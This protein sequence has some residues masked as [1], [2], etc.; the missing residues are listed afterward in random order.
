M[1]KA[2]YILISVCGPTAAGKTTLAIELAKYFQTEIISADSRQ[3]YRE[4]EIGTAKPSTEELAAVPHHFINSHSITE[5]FSVADFEKAALTKLEELF[6]QHK[7]VLMVGGSGLYL[8]AIYQGFDD[9]PNA[10]PQEREHWNQAYQEFGLEYLQ[11]QL[12]IL[13]PEYYE[14]VD[15]QNPQRII[16]AL[17]ISAST[18]KPFS[19]FLTKTKKERDFKIIKIG[20]NPERAILYERINNRVDEMVKNGLVKEA[21]DLLPQQHLNALNTV[22]YKEIF[23]AFNKKTPVKEALT[24]IKQNTRHFAKRQ[25][26]WFKKDQEILWFDSPDLQAV[27]SV[28]LPL[29]G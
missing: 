11:N 14:Q 18:G 22:G 24:L 25:I 5:N 15:L 28:L 16:R 23:D 19:S 9:L 8:Q 29:I 13:D 12:K 26:T 21:S 10:E 3:F 17:E 7:I 1:V 6:Q 4:T 27:L 20:I 2:K